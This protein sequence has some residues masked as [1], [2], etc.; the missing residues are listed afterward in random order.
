M[1][2]A[3]QEGPPPRREE[4]PRTETETTIPPKPK[5]YFSGYFQTPELI[6]QD[7]Y[8]VPKKEIEIEGKDRKPFKT[9]ETIR[10]AAGRIVGLPPL[11]KGESW[12]T[13]IG[14]DGK[15][16]ATKNT[17]AVSKELEKNDWGMDELGEVAGG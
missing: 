3:P 12:F 16:Y 5:G 2:I 14:P 6:A 13:F 11:A 1:G 10:D 7:F 9:K 8:E 4:K 15:E 17:E